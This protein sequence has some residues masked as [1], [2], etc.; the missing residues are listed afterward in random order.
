MITVPF[1]F[2]ILT[3]R[4]LT[5]TSFRVP[6]LMLSSDVIW[7][8]EKAVSLALDLANLET[9]A[10]FSSALAPCVDPPLSLRQEQDSKE[11]GLCA[12]RR[13]TQERD[14]RPLCAGLRT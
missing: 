12:K 1:L 2:R 8:I 14:S 11:A 3:R 7:N 5:C 6:F 13:R 4:I 9:L 10:A